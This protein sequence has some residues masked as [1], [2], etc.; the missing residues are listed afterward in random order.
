MASRKVKLSGLAT[1]KQ[2]ARILL[3]TF[4][5]VHLLQTKRFL[6]TYCQLQSQLKLLVLQKLLDL[7]GYGHWNEPPNKVITCHIYNICAVNKTKKKSVTKMQ[8][9]ERSNTLSEKKSWLIRTWINQIQGQCEQYH[10]AESRRMYLLW[11]EIPK[12]TQLYHLLLV[13]WPPPICS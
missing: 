5:Q 6:S 13:V 10:K 2:K 9:W 11:S 7:R 3:C 1:V 12:D 4:A 8:R